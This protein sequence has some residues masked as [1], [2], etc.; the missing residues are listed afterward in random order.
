MNRES[1]V[2][3]GN[4]CCRGSSRVE[5]QWLSSR[6]G[7]TRP[8]TGS[9]WPVRTAS[10]S[11]GSPGRSPGPI[12]CRCR[13][14]PAAAHRHR[15]CSPTTART[16]FSADRGVPGIEIALADGLEDSVGDARGRRG[17]QVRRRIVEQRVPQTRFVL[18]LRRVP[19][20]VRRAPRSGT[21]GPGRSSGRS[22]SSRKSGITMVTQ[23][24][25]RAHRALAK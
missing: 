23:E 7:S 9:P 19:R 1:L 6:C 3:P 10:R 21:G 15:K 14:R 5:R 12:P 18:Q 24:F 2:S 22:S 25:P 17:L 20:P 4:D 11:A 13:T 8:G 16:A